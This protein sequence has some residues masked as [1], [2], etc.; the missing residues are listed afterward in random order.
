MYLSSLQESAINVY[1]ITTSLQSK[2]SINLVLN[3]IIYI[4]EKK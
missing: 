2:S 1:V 3:E 4:Q